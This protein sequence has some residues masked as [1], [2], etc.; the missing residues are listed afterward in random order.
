MKQAL[1]LFGRSIG[2][3]AVALILSLIVL[4]G[5]GGAAR[6]L[7]ISLN[8]LVVAGMG[9]MMFM[10]AGYR[11]ERACTMLATVDRIRSEGREPGADMLKDCFSKKVAAIAYALIAAVFLIF[12]VVNIIA[13]P[14][15]PPVIV[16]PVEEEMTVEEL[17]AMYESMTEE[18]LAQM[19]AEAEQ[20]RADTN[21]F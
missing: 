10:D 5:V 12:A 6:W 9:Y 19:Q 15:Y 7:Q 16:S 18:E 13:A 8:A 1:R 11:G 17:A 14:Y 3:Y 21:Y 20:A 2:T 4:A